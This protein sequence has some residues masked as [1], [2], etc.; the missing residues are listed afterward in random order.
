M[1]TEV[2]PEIDEYEDEFEE[3]EDFRAMSRASIASMVFIDPRTARSVGRGRA[4]LGCGPT[5]SP[6]RALREHSRTSSCLLT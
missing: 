4:S 6:R 2:D 5:A 1:A 3:F